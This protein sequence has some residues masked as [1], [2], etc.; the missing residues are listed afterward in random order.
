MVL[1]ILTCKR[2]RGVRERCIQVALVTDD[3]ARLLGRGAHLREIGGRVVARVRA[4]VPLD[5]HGVT[6]AHGRICGIRDHCRAT[7][8]SELCR[9]N[10][11]LDQNNLLDAGHLERVG[12]V[13]LPYLAA[14]DRRAGD[15]CVLHAGH[16]HVG[17]I[18]GVAGRDVVQVHHG[19]FALAHVKKLVGLLESQLLTRRHGQLHRRGRQLAE[20]ET[21]VG[22]ALAVGS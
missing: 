10:G 13:E 12:E 6:A 22:L 15:D 19:R 3:L 18:D 14:D 2:V 16:T 5:D 20:A 21:L 7:E 17:A 4:V 11:A 8:R 1:V 9:R